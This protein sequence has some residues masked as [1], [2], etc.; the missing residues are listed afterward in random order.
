MTNNLLETMPEDGAGS[1]AAAQPPSAIPP[2]GEA[3]ENGAGPTPPPGLPDKFWD[4]D[5]GEVR[6]DSLV[7]SYRSLEQKLG[8]LAGQGV[9]DDAEGYD[10]KTENELF[11]SDPAVN[12][13]LHAAG[14][15]Q[16]Q[17]QTVYDLAAE[18]MLPLVTGVASE[19]HAQAQIDRLAQRFGGEEKWREMAGQLKQWGRAKF[20]DEVFQALSSTYEG[21]LTMH[22][23][24]SSGEPGL[25]E[26][27]GAGDEGSSEEGLKRMMQDPRY[28]RDHDP[29]FVQRVQDGFKR[30]FPD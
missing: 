17:A 14:F 24:M 4:Q 16:E 25:I 21:V 23:M 5:K 10:I 15:S 2:Q 7:K 12:A 18:H 27:A 30:L 28:W 19:F 22:K 29:S 13:Q 9:P 1:G 3:P 20:P 8:A 26:G 6:T 11:A